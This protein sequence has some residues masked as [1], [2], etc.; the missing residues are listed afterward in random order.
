MIPG[1]YK[2][3]SATLT[4]EKQHQHS[5]FGYYGYI[6]EQEVLPGRKSLL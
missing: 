6:G 4:D 3:V 1:G 5:C 2:N